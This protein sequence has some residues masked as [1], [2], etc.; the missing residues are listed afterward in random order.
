MS[1]PRVQLIAADFFERP[2]KLRLPFRFGVVTLTQA[3]QVF[4]RAR[5]GLA[6][7]RESE[8]VSAE[9]LAP[10]WFDKSAALSNEDN[11]DQLRRSLGMARTSLIAAGSNTPFG[12][13]AAVDQ[14]HHEECAKVGLNGL[15]ASF[16]L[17]LLDR[18]IAR[19]L[20]AVPKRLVRAFASPYIAGAE[21][22]SQ[23]EPQQCRRHMGGGL[24]PTSRQECAPAQGAS[25]SR[26]HRSALC[27]IR[28]LEGAAMMLLRRGE[29]HTFSGGDAQYLYLVPSAAVVKL[30]DQALHCVPSVALTHRVSVPMIGPSALDRPLLPS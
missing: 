5:I 7:G 10:K 24:V 23:L 28:P 1:A 26:R 12:L 18:A 16:G 17:A 30:D 22:G 9:M 15:V 4:V 6:D 27:E 3:P 2:V 25:P 19:V 20:P 29:Y 8:G 11:F 13:S 14:S 21:P